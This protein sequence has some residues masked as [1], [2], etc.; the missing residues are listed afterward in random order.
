MSQWIEIIDRSQITVYSHVLKKKI[1]RADLVGKD[2]REA[3]FQ[4]A[5]LRDA[6]LQKALLQDADLRNADLR[7]ASLIGT[8]FQGADLRDAD[9][10]DARLIGAK[11]QGADL[12]GADLRGAC[13]YG[14]N[15]EDAKLQGAKL[16]GADFGKI[17]NPPPELCDFL[18]ED[19]LSDIQK[20]SEAPYKFITEY[21]MT[22]SH[23]YEDVVDRIKDLKKQST[24][25]KKEYQ[26]IL[27]KLLK[28]MKSKISLKHKIMRALE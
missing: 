3:K 24:M 20:R 10:R 6:L 12:R 5:N 16:Q 7:E 13:L 2:L 9:L 4:G 21:W 14:A 27:N 8:E 11:L 25:E 23:V 18:I 22:E 15:I 19:L 26:K 17:E 28:Q 1:S